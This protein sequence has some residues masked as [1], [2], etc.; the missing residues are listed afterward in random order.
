[1]DCSS[2]DDQSGTPP[3]EYT[4]GDSEWRD[5][6]P[7][8]RCGNGNGNGGANGQGSLH[9]KK[10]KNDPGLWEDMEDEKRNRYFDAE[11]AQHLKQAFKKIGEEITTANVRL[12]N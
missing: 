7:R 9:C 1:M 3:T 10:N 6:K 2:Y 5:Q 11:D 4:P 12:I 8:E